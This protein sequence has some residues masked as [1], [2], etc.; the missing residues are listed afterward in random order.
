MLQAA[1]GTTAIAGAFVLAVTLSTSH[2]PKFSPETFTGELVS[3]GQTI[4]A[5]QA[6]QAGSAP[7]KRFTISG[8]VVDLY[9]GAQQTLTLRF[10]NPLQQEIKVITAVV[11]V[12][13]TNKPGCPTSSV[14]TTN[15]TAPAGGGVIVAKKGT[16]TLN[17]PISM[18]ADADNRCSGATF[19]LAYSGTAVQ[20]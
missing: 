16:A 20:S 1:G 7:A 8:S 19:S 3:R 5:P 18:G 2:G 11:T 12:Q 10:E 17:L 15:Y 6:P 4:P 9:P 14:T 13:S